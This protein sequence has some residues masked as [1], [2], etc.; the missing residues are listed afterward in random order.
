MISEPSAFMA[1]ID[2]IN[3]LGTW[4]FRSGGNVNEVMLTIVWIIEA[5]A[6]IAFPMFFA[7]SKAGEPYLENDDDWAE[8]TVIG[9][10]EYIPNGEILQKQL[11]AKNYEEL[12]AMKPAKNA[13]QGSHSLLELYHSKHRNQSK[14]F[15]LSV[16]NMHQK[17]SKDGKLEFD[18]KV[19]ISYISISKEAGQQLLAKVTSQ[20]AV[21][22]MKD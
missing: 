17:H 9:P 16:K 19:L 3:N 2:V 20:T 8:N 21:V 1:S 18:E 7:Y 4:G 13:G 14:E 6:F 12:V 22:E 11:E 5:L 15:Y 10:F